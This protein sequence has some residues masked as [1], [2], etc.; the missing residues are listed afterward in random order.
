MLA[1]I[2][3]FFLGRTTLCGKLG[4]GVYEGHLMRQSSFN[5]RSR[6]AAFTLTISD[7]SFVQK[8]TGTDS[9]VG[10]ILALSDC[11]YTLTQIKSALTDST[12]L[13]RLINSRGPIVIEMQ[14]IRGNRLYFRTRHKNDLHVVTSEG[15]LIKIK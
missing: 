14:E 15:Y 2:L 10:K 9:V 3:L 11:S 12:D 13:D 1:I 7:S 4:N 6:G 8:R 5:E